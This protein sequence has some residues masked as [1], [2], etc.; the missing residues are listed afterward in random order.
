MSKDL[1]LIDT[2]SMASTI[3]GPST[4]THTTITE[5]P[6]DYPESVPYPG[7]VFIIRHHDTGKVI[8]LVNGE[9]RLSEGLS[10][11]GGY[12]WQCIEKDRWLGFRNCVSGTI[13]GHNDK[14]K[15]IA[16]AEKHLSFEFFTL[17]PHPQ[18][19]YELLVRHGYEL[20]SMTVGINGNE[21]VE[22]KDEGDLW[23]F[24]KT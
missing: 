22:T 19:G 15:F 10:P 20:W 4:P 2:I 24:L 13:I 3:E 17:R 23:H 12:H 5:A 6:T 9:L 21:L 8:T 7:A 1:E 11:T 14:K 18:G 16:K